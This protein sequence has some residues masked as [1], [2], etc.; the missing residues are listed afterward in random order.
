MRNN[1][2]KVYIMQFCNHDLDVTNFRGSFPLG[3]AFIFTEY[4]SHKARHGPEN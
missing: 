3:I 1:P 2:H 4:V